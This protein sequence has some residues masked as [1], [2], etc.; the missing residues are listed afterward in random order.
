MA[1]HNA[2]DLT[3]QKFGR[4]TV[5]APADA[6][7]YGKERDKKSMFMCHCECGKSVEVAGNSLKTGNTKSCGCLNI[8]RLKSRAKGLRGER[9]YRIWQAMLNRCRNANQPNYANYGGR[10]IKVCE[11][12]L[13][14]ENFISDMGRPDEDQSIDRIDNDGNYEPGNCRWASRKQQNRNKNS[15]RV[16]TLDGKSMTL[17]EWAESLG[18]EQSS[19]RERLKK[20]TLRKALTTP[21]IDRKAA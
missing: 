11:R 15:N 18:I 5:I 2:I 9:V 21:K 4:L 12:W 20:W 16:L 8:D 6:K 14:I 3:G 13:S 17:I 1:S 7:E 10:G 19:L